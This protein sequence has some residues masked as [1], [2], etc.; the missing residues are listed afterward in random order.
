[1]IEQVR[2]SSSS[3]SASLLERAK[4][5]DPE[6]WRRLSRLYV[7][8]VYRWA[9]RAG[10]QESDAADVVQ[11]AFHSLA[12]NMSRFRGDQPA[13]S[14]RGWLY[15]I[16]RNK[17]HDHFRK[18]AD[19]PDAP[20]GSQVDRWLQRLS[21]EPT[22]TDVRD[23]TTELAQRALSLMQSDFEA[24]TWQVFWSVVVE[25]RPPAEIAAEKNMSLASVYQA[26]SRVLRRLRQEL[27]GL[28]D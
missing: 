13:S 15:T 11:E 3:T 22:E 4:A 17:I 14:F 8:V 26:K 18:L 23:L 6:A 12:I 28:L 5:Q 10:L 16:T 7:P 24:Q 9:R 1:M 21:E 25:E 20:G 2:E 27:D 19:R